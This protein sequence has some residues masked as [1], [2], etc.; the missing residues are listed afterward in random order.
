MPQMLPW[1]ALRSV[2]VSDRLPSSLRC[3][4]AAVRSNDSV[5]QEWRLAVQANSV[6]LL[7]KWQFGVR[8]PHR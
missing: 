5:T 3:G 7:A 8:A 4:G 6:S 1:P 2:N